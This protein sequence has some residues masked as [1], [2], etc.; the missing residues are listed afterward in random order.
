MRH[1]RFGDGAKGAKP[2]NA[3]APFRDGAEQGIF[4]LFFGYAE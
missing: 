4:C 2:E 3:L 1:S